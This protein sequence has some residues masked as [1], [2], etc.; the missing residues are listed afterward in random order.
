M[1]EEETMHYASMALYHLSC[2]AQT[3]EAL[4]RHGAHQVL[5]RIAA[6]ASTACRLQAARALARLCLDVRWQHVLLAFRVMGPLVELALQALFTDMQRDA[7]TAIKTLASNP[8]LRE[9]VLAELRVSMGARGIF[10]AG[11]EGRAMRNGRLNGAPADAALEGEVADGEEKENTP[12]QDR[13]LSLGA[14]SHK[15]KL[16]SGF[17]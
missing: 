6:S 2:C 3:T 13:L 11:H 1:V 15:S 14:N 5:V 7:L 10:I 4:I 12:P 8:Q 9:T 17:T 16:H